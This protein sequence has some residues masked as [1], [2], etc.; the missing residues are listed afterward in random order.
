MNTVLLI[1]SSDLQEQKAPQFGNDVF[2]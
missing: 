2:E 1:A